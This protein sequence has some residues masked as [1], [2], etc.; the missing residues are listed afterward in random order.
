M[1][2]N[3]FDSYGVFC[4]ADRLINLGLSDLNDGLDIV[5]EE[6]VGEYNKFLNS[7]YNV[8]TKSELDCIDE[9]LNNAF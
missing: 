1:E 3:H 6:A 4:M 2:T 7:K 9:Y 5:W 8:D